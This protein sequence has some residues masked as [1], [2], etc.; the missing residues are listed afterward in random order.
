MLVGRT[1]ERAAI[2]SLL[3]EAR[4][5]HGRVCV[6]EGP[7]GIGKSALI[8]HVQDTVEGFLVVRAVGV[9]AEMQLP[10]AQLQQLCAPLAAYTER[11]PPA[12]RDALAAALGQSSERAGDP[13]L[14]ALA[15]V[16]LL[17]VAAAEQPVLLVVDDAQWLD[18]ASSRTV[19]F[20][21]RRLEV[22]AVA[23]LVARRPPSG[24]DMFAGLTVKALSPLSFWDS[25][26]L[27]RRGLRVRLDPTVATRM[28]VESR[29]NPLALLE[30]PRRADA[31]SLAGGYQPVVAG[32]V[33]P[34]LE[35]EFTERV[36]ALEPD[37]RSILLLA[38]AEPTGDPLLL[39]RATAA[40]GIDLQ[41]H[42]EG[43]S[44]LLHVDGMVAFRHPLI[45]SVAY[46]AAE[47]DD[48]RRAHAVLAQVTDAEAEP[49]RQAW[50]L[51]A[52]A[53]APREELAEVL[54]AAAERAHRRGGLL[55]AASFLERA[56]HLSTDV[57][58]RSE[59]AL[60][61]AET[62][63]LAGRLNEAMPLL[64]LAET[65]ATDER[66]AARALMVRGR[67]AQAS[68]RGVDAA[69]YCWEAARRL[70]DLDPQAAAETYLESLSAAL[71][72]GS[73]GTEPSA[74]EI[75]RGVLGRPRPRSTEERPTQLLVDALAGLVVEGPAVAAPRIR[76]AVDAFRLGDLSQS[77]ELRWTWLTARLAALAWDEVAWAALVRRG[78]RAAREAGSLLAIPTILSSGAVLSTLSGRTTSGRVDAEEAEAV[79]ESLGMDHPRYGGLAVEAW[80][81]TDCSAVIDAGLA[82]PAAMRGEGMAVALAHWSGAMIANAVGDRETALRHAQ[83][84]AAYPRGLL[85]TDWSLL[86][87]VEAAS[88]SRDADTA[89][90]AFER[91]VES[92]SAAGTPWAAGVEARARGLVTHSPVEAES[93]FAESVAHL[94]QTGLVAELARS[95]L[96]FGEWLRRQRRRRLAREHL[97]RARD[98]FM[99][100]GARGFAARAEAELRAAGAAVAPAPADT[101]QA[102]MLSAQERR[103]ATLA[104]EGLTNT[105]IAAQLFLSPNTVDYHLRKVFLKL[106]ISSR[107]QI[108]AALADRV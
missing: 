29:G 22:D 44:G 84:S 51:A 74:A 88:V 107:A 13:T 105:E 12:Q 48:R 97:Q 83:V 20:A 98:L 34:L 54:E 62:Y 11:L 32:D 40:V 80:T 106:A 37:P 31:A 70:E 21:A 10:F 46:T 30:L 59:R 81:A 3:R 67:A 14:T 4:A 76:A 73:P 55:A 90:A 50:H 43:I 5:G 100:M 87:I 2:D 1:A 64:A 104:S 77:D 9:E 96:L 103:V 28:A 56:A 63:E 89:R 95:H 94:Q 24:P 35:N 53:T 16:S 39:W 45:R 92:T 36:R 61:A 25:L 15:F 23:M 49:D 19:A 6:L 33:T 101:T 72:T 69:V 47:P 99:G 65:R 102:E 93:A 27:L 8:E 52:A 68:H 108:H 60:R 86:E 38:A 85:Y 58:M 57:S 66:L 42:L 17:S 82:T 18:D 7:P 78:V 75:A 41:S 79:W 26:A 91:L 71:I